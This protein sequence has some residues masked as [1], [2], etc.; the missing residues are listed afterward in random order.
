MWVLENLA[1]R[2]IFGIK[3]KEVTGWWRKL[4]NKK[5]YNFHSLPDVTTVMRW[6]RNIARM[7]EVK[8]VCVL[9]GKL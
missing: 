2:R 6:A 1:L 5:R 8:N 7:V 3:T 4:F 9:V